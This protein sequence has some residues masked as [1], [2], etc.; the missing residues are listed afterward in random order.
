MR[1]SFA[2]THVCVCVAHCKHRLQPFVFAV[3][4]MQSIR[5]RM[6]VFVCVRGVIDR[7]HVREVSLIYVHIA[8]IVSTSLCFCVTIKDSAYLS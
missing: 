4:E 3:E 2:P 6:C 5:R 1:T 7:G 8:P